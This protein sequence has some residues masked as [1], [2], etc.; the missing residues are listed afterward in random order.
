[1]KETRTPILRREPP[2]A[3]LPWVDRVCKWSLVFPRELIPRVRK[4]ARRKG[5][6]RA[7]RRRVRTP[8]GA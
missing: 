7:L 8:M 1:M 5:R 6:R 4:A 2:S 3:R